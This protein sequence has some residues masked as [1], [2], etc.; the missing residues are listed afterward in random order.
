ME[1]LDALTRATAEYRQRL[2][3][4]G[5]DQWNEPSVCSGWSVKDLADHVLGGNR[6][7]VALVD[8]ASTDEAL[9]YAL[10]G[11][12]DGDP[13]ARF[14]ES[15]DAQLAAFS[16]PGALE[17]IVHHPE[18]DI[19]GRTFLYYRVGDLLLHG[20]D[21]ARSTGGDDR[22]DEELVPDVW[23]EYQQ[24]LDAA[25]DNGAFGTGPSGTVP[26]D[27]PLSHRLLDLTGR[28]P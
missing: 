10:T 28:N 3:D 27:A 18:G 2:V 15:A 25:A 21:L 16:R 17:A 8:G 1:P 24:L 13:V 4:V 22:L 9:T 5:A 26:A 11:S 19:N 12:F 20:W 23:R 7:A 14:V 6:F